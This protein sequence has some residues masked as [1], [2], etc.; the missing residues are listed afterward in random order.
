MIASDGTW[1]INRGTNEPDGF[2]LYDDLEQTTPHD[3]TANGG[4]TALLQVR[5]REGSE[6]L[7]ELKT[8][9]STITLSAA[10]EI[11]FKPTVEQTR[12]LPKNE[13]FK[14]QLKYT[15]AGITYS[16]I[17]AEVNTSEEIAV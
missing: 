5:K 6:V 10:G 14:Y 16:L 2:V 15:Q 3:F 1:Y 17:I 12:A 4:S 8:D 13:K 9:N 11:L 7:M